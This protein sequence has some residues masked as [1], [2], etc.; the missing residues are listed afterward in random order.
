MATAPMDIPTVTH[1]LVLLQRG[2]NHAAAAGHF[3][4]HAQFVGAMEAAKTALLGGSFG[5]PID[6]AD[7]GYLLHV[8]SRAEAEAVASQDPRARAFARRGLSS[9]IWWESVG[10][11]LMRRSGMRAEGSAPG[12][13][14]FKHVR[15]AAPMFGVRSRQDRLHRPARRERQG[16]SVAEAHHDVRPAA[17]HPQKAC[18]LRP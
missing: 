17:G 14:T 8:A 3:A 13:L 1:F 18:E 2:E 4:A 6:G 12:F 11:R 5:S 10:A 7:G 16:G 15:P 9:G